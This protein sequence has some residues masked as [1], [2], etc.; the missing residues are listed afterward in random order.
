MMAMEKMTASRPTPAQLMTV[1]GDPASLPGSAWRRVINASMTAATTQETRS[2]KLAL[3]LTTRL[4]HKSR[5]TSHWRE[6]PRDP[7]E[8]TL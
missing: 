1:V 8:G 7:S 2:R 6:R 5:G 4:S 3:A